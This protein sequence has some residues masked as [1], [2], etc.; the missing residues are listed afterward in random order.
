VSNPFIVWDLPT[1]LFHWILVAL[2]AAQYASGEFGWLPMSWHYWLGYVTLALIVFRVL[3]GFAGS[4]T[5]RFAGFVRG[6]RA[7]L[8]HVADALRGRAEHVPGHN[9]L[10]GWSVLAMLATLAVQATSGLF[11]SDDIS[12][13]GPFAAQVS[14]AT[15]AAM[16]RIHNLGRQALLVLITLHIAAVLL[17]WVIRNDNLVAPMLHGRAR[18]AQVRALRFASSWRALLIFAISAAAVWA[19]V[20][21]F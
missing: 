10:G 13:E 6:P 17:H 20:A 9:P 21:L 15:V 8:R 1:R 16:T 3:W 12:E 5:S 19:L 14:D 7:V 4:E 2:V 18:F 11:A